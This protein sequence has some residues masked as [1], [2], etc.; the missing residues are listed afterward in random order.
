MG[1]NPNTEEHKRFRKV[2]DWVSAFDGG[3]INV[4]TDTINP[5]KNHDISAFDGISETLPPGEK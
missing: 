5:L 4:Y 3:A 1:F 2:G